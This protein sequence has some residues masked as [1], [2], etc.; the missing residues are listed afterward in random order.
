MGLKKVLISS[1]CL[2]FV[3]MLLLIIYSQSA[4]QIMISLFIFGT[5]FGISST[6]NMAYLGNSILFPTEVL[7]ISFGACNLFARVSTI[8]APFVAELKPEAVSQRIFCTIV[9]LAL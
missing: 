2:S 4:G 3:G 1:F 5:K 9:M 8:L 7:S 6:C